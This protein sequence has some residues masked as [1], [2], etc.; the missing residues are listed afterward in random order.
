VRYLSIRHLDCITARAYVATV[1]V[2]QR[3]C[4]HFRARV[5]QHMRFKSKP[6]SFLDV[7]R[8]DWQFEAFAWLLRNSGGHQKFL[9][10]TLVLPTEEHFPDRGMRGHA[11]VAALFRRARD[12]AGMADWPCTVEAETSE[13]RSVDPESENIRVF[14]YRR[15]SLEPISLVAGFGCGFARYLIETYDEPAP[16]GE[17]ARE[18]A[19]EIAAVFMGFGVFLANSAVRQ[20]GYQLSEGELA[21]ALALFCLLRGLPE[22]TAEK[23]LNPHLHKYVRLAA[24]D[25]AQ[26]ETKFQKL[27]NVNAVAERAAG[28][29]LPTRAS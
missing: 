16:G 10:T 17:S 26:H 14:T 2:A 21:H 5:S 19:V 3:A 4:D 29:A 11:G 18:A 27:R 7:S 13:P 23:H 28:A 24:L 25:L 6:K 15:G 20:A 9:E 12:H 8:R 1:T 22:E